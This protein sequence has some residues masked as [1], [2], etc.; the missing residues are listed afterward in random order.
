[1]PEFCI[2]LIALKMKPGFQENERA[3]Q[4][5]KQFQNPRRKDELS[6]SIKV[7]VGSAWDIGF[8]DFHY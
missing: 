7:R 3:G 6:L 1:M 2:V 5:T 8:E 4:G